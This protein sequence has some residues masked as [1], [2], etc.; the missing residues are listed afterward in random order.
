MARNWGTI[1]ATFTV[2][3][4]GIRWEVYFDLETREIEIIAAE[5]ETDA[6]GKRI[7]ICERRE[8]GGLKPCATHA[9]EVLRDVLEKNAI[10]SSRSRSPQATRKVK[11]TRPRIHRG[12]QT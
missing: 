11:P 2:L 4:E 3:A 7:E 9:A 8:L 6:D 5:E 10:T 12:A 1:N